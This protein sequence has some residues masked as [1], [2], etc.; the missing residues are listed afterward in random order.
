MQAEFKWL[1][2][3]FSGQAY[4]ALMDFF[5]LYEI[6]ADEVILSPAL[7]NDKNKL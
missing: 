6:P 2:S 7:L 4:K 5:G 1:D 3:L